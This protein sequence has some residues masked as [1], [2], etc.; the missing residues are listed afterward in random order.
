[1]P[2][3]YKYIYDNVTKELYTEEQLTLGNAEIREIESIDVYVK[4]LKN[5]QVVLW[6][7]EHTMVPTRIMTG[8]K[9][10]GVDEPVNDRVTWE[11][12][13]D[14]VIVKALSAGTDEITL[15][16]SDYKQVIVHITVVN[17]M[18]TMLLP[19]NLMSID[20]Q[21]FVG[22]KP[23]RVVLPGSIRSVS[24][25]AFQG[26]TGVQMDLPNGMDRDVLDAILC[27]GPVY[28]TYDAAQAEHILQAGCVAVLLN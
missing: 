13:G 12:N 8:C 15:R 20:D 21:A 7:G 28:A 19:E 25:T 18:M 4:M 14:D 24:A 11:E 22:T 1:M 10:E 6:S 27:E 2:A 5:D 3:T 16:L 17:S 26:M 23:E 9:L